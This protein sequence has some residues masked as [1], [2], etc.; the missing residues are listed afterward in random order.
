MSNKIQIEDQN[1][2]INTPVSNTVNMFFIII[3]QVYESFM[4]NFIGNAL[5]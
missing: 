4:G 5:S 1:M 2:V 3:I